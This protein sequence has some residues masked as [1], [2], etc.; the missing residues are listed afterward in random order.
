MG[1]ARHDKA[2]HI[3]ASCLQH[4]A[5][6]EEHVRLHDDAVADDRHDMGIEDPARDQLQGEGLPVDDDGVTG[7]VTALVTDH[8]LDVLCQQVC[9]LAFAL[10]APLGSDHYGRRH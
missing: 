9:Q 6:G 3:D 8:D 7:V 4:G 2:A 5:L 10:V 1:V